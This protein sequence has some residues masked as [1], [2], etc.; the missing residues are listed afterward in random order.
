MSIIHPQPTTR[1]TLSM[2]MVMRGKKR[3]DDLW[4]ASRLSAEVGFQY[5]VKKEKYMPTAGLERPDFA[6]P[7]RDGNR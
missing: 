5:S 3:R 6:S 2:E 1:R 4:A 7:T